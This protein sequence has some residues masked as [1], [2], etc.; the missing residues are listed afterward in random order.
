[1][2]RVKFVI[3]INTAALTSSRISLTQPHSCYKKLLLAE[4]GSQVA[5]HKRNNSSYVLSLALTQ[6]DTGLVNLDPE[7][8]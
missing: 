5:L 2:A 6:F 8:N 1:M 3:R 7:T 4:A